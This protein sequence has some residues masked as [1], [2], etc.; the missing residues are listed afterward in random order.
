MSNQKAYFLV[1]RQKVGEHSG[2]PTGGLEMDAEVVGGE[3]APDYKLAF[4]LITQ[5]YHCAPG[6]SLI[7]REVFDAE[8]QWDA[9][10]LHNAWELEMRDFLELMKV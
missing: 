1:Y 8:D 9:H 5:R 3:L 6:E 4:C 10:L 7:F 2:E